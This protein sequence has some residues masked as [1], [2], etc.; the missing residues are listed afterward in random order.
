MLA[1]WAHP[2][3]RELVQSVRWTKAHRK[4]T[5]DEPP[6][7]LRDI[8]GNNA[9][10]KAANEARDLHPPLGPDVKAAVAFASRRAP[11]VARAVSAA[12]ELFPRAPGDMQRKPRPKTIKQA[13]DGDLHF[14]RHQQGT[15]RCTRCQSW[16]SHGRLPRSRLHERCVGVDLDAEARRFADNGHVMCR[17]TGLLPFSFCSR[18]GGWKNRRSY[19][20]SRPCAPPTAAGEQALRRITA[21]WHPWRRKQANG[22]ADEQR[23]RVSVLAAYDSSTSQWGFVGQHGHPSPEEEGTGAA[24][25]TNID[26]G[27]GPTA[28]ADAPLRV[29]RRRLGGEEALASEGTLPRAMTVEAAEALMTD[30]GD[31]ED[32]FNHGGGLDE[33]PTPRDEAGDA[34]GSGSKSASAM[35]T[36]VRDHRLEGVSMNMLVNTMKDL[37]KRLGDADAVRLFDATNGVIVE[38]TV[39]CAEAEISWRRARGVRDDDEQAPEPAKRQRQHKEAPDAGGGGAA[40]LPRRTGSGDSDP[41]GALFTSRAQLLKALQ[42]PRAAA[43]GEEAGVRRPALRA[44]A[45]SPHRVDHQLHRPHHP[46]PARAAL[47]LRVGGA[48]PGGAVQ[49]GGGSSDADR[50]VRRRVAFAADQCDDEESD[51]KREALG[52][53]GDLPA[54]GQLAK[55]RWAHCRGQ[56]RGPGHGLGEGFARAGAEDAHAV[57]LEGI[58]ARPQ[59]QAR[60]EAARLAPAADGDLGDS[61]GARRGAVHGVPG[62]DVG[63]VPCVKPRWTDGGGED[64][65]ETYDPLGSPG[66]EEVRGAHPRGAAART[67]PRCR[68]R[69]P[70]IGEGGPRLRPVRRR[71]RSKTPAVTAGASAAHATPSRSSGSC[72]PPPSPWRHTRTEGLT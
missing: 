6:E 34:A 7:V 57:Q 69:S 53:G 10:D 50:R 38:T 13:Q 52:A 14:W 2:H 63:I 70:S 21:G 43:G 11:L 27:T 72:A 48:D 15:W 59:P 65:S 64:G 18:C 56:S 22:E 60:R 44:L 66:D 67:R 54:A 29:K 68:S 20:L 16:T 4:P 25:V 42:A 41:P 51:H 24:T 62:S 1:T 45:A 3:Q 9:A 58:A 40:S 8:T 71:L 23:T 35:D 37:P 33:L 31:E 55:S 49:R 26:M 47:R 39:R 5:G 28:E 46:R 61:D 12:L 36:A 30:V 32:V 19:K 17:A